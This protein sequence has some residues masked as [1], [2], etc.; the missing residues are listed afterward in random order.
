M[1]IYLPD[2]EIACLGE[3]HSFIGQ[4]EKAPAHFRL[5]AVDEAARG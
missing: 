2:Q 5:L 3:I 1:L 4:R